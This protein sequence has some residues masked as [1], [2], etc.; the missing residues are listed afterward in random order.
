MFSNFHFVVKPSTVNAAHLLS[1]RMQRVR[2]QDPHG[3]ELVIAQ[4]GDFEKLELHS[5][6][7]KDYSGIVAQLSEHEFEVN[8]KMTTEETTCPEVQ[9]KHYRNH[10][11]MMEELML[12]ERNEELEFKPVRLRG[13]DPRKAR[14]GLASFSD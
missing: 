4:L 7:D 8:K 10:E 11:E 6:L 3:F 2:K 13:R 9:R 14:R 5:M 1:L 12:D